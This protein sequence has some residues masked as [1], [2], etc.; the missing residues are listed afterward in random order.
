MKPTVRVIVPVFKAERY[1]DKC[2]QSILDQTFQ[3]FEL[4]LV[5]DGSPDRCGE[6][7]D[8][9][10]K[11][12]SRVRVIHKANGGQADARNKALDLACGDYIVFVDSDDWIKEDMLAT[13]YALIQDTDTD[14]ACC[15]FFSINEDGSQ[16]WETAKI[17]PGLW[18]Q[19]DFWHQYFCHSSK[20]YYDIVCCKL[21]K[22]E[23]FENVRFL[24]GHIHE[25]TYIIYSLVSQCS[26]IAA[27][28]KIE[29]YYL[30]HEASTMNTPKSIR[31][32]TSPKAHIN[33]AQAF[34]ERQKW[35][36]SEES[37]MSAI[38]EML[39]GE[40]GEGGKR[41]REYKAL[42]RE[43]K[44]LYHRLFKHLGLK[45][46]IS[47]SLFFISEPLAR[48]FRKVFLIGRS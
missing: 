13:L 28:D 26:K 6:M 31:N 46:K 1:L 37:L 17:T 44:A 9:W 15:N 11:K 48:T 8:G 16:H 42:K 25:D 38:H 27:T 4:I 32:L 36:F 47:M 14:M 40:Y 22:K 43:A 21:Y 5:D 18:T 45:R 19:D 23:L 2:V 10:E 30:F 35:F 29:Y 20:T 24:T 33:R 41:S 39:L 7:C 12:D 34:A 3:D